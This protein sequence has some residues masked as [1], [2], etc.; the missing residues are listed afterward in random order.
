[1]RQLE[2]AVL[3]NDRAR[4]KS[5]LQATQAMLAR[6]SLSGSGPM[7]PEVAAREEQR[8]RVEL[9]IV[10]LASEL[11]AKTAERVALADKLSKI[12]ELDGQLRSRPIYRAIDKTVEVAFVPYTQI[13]GVRRGAP[14]YDCTWGLFRCR[15]VGEIAEVVPGEVVSPDP[16]GSQARG[17]YAILDLSDHAAARSKMLRVRGAATD[18]AHRESAGALSGR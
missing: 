17:Q 5:R 12:D 4:V 2:V 18:A 15:V 11:R 6:S 9:E 13:Q 16:W 7:M 8:V 1:M 10:R 3:D 14:V